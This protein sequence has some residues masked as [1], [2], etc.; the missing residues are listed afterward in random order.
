MTI[1]PPAGVGFL[2]T[3]PTGSFQ[4][5]VST[6]NASTG[7]VTSNLA[8]VPA[9]NNGAIDVFVTDQTQVV[10]DV[11]GYFAPPG[12]PGALNFYTVTPCRIA[13]TR[14]AAGPFGGPRLEANETRSFAVP[15][16]GCGTPSD[17]RAYSLNA[18]LVPPAPVGFLTLWGSGT[19]PGVSNLNSYDGA[20]VA[21]AAI[22]PA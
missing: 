21:V 12:G 11:T 7:T 22:T 8:I 20:I 18:T 5:L 14:N 17:A 9:G 2:K 6:L 3:W 10:I 19:P 13:D 15:S 16:S 1:D 4:P